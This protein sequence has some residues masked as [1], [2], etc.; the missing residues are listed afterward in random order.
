MKARRS[1]QKSTHRLRRSL[2]E[3]LREFLTPALWKQ[4]HQ[5]R[6]QTQ[7][8]QSSRWM[9]QPLVLMLLLM[10]W[11]HGDSQAD[12]FECAKAYCQVC[13]QKRR[14]PGK[15]V[16]GFQ[17]ALA[18]LPLAVLRTVA[19][20]VRKV[21]AARLGDHWF[22]EGFVPIGCDGSRVECP[23]TTELEERMGQAG[24][25]K[26]APTL[27]VTALVHLRW[28][29]PWAWRFGKGTASER[30]HLLQMLRVLPRLALLVADAGYFGFRLT[31]QLVRRHVLFVLRMSDAAFMTRYLVGIDLGRLVT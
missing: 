17:K 3:I 30:E 16:Q 28:G 9:V 13:L 20:G 26:A 12:R 19:A 14:R 4:A 10:T 8:K 2:V 25:D 11:S 15:T 31:E 23:R 1:S 24:K 22:V 21:L 7:R 5:A 29:V 18:R 27:W 6:R